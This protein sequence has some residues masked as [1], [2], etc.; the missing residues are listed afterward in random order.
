MVERFHAQL[1]SSPKAQQYLINRS[2]DPLMWEKFQLGYVEDNSVQCERF[3]GRILF[4]YHNA[5]KDP[6][7]WTARSLG[8]NDPKYLNT[9]E[10][11]I[12]QKSRILYAFAFAAEKIKQTGT[13]VLVEGQ[14]DCIRL[15]QV[16]V[17]SAVATAGAGMK[18][19]AARLLS[20]Y[21]KRCYIVYDNDPAGNKGAKDAAETLS[22]VGIKSKIVQLPMTLD[23]D[24]Y[25]LMYGKDEFVNLLKTTK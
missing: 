13:A 5:W 12:C 10:S 25:V 18:T 16:G 17:T 2:I 1:L 19:A 20:R 22:Q 9:Y 8:D 11:P 14:V 4:P 3:R 23:P 21:A 15:H 24:K 6:V 7:G